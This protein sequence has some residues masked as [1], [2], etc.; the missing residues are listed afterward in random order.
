MT[1]YA[2]Y[3]AANRLPGVRSGSSKTLYTLEWRCIEP[4]RDTGYKHKISAQIRVYEALYRAMA[5]KQYEIM[6][7]HLCVQKREQLI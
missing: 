4:V 7:R 6:T 3:D 1:S 5:R 2:M